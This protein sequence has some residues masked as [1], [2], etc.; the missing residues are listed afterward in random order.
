MITIK[1]INHDDN[2]PYVIEDD[3]WGS[4]IC[5][6]IECLKDLHQQIS[7]IIEQSEPQP[8]IQQHGSIGGMMVR[9]MIESIEKGY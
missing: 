7:Q 6:S 9:K 2:S 4:K 5:C 8:R 3:D 1:K